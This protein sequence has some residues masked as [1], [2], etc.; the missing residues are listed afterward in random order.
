MLSG[1]KYFG[2]KLPCGTYINKG[3]FSTVMISAN[4]LLSRKDVHMQKWKLYG[5]KHVS[6]SFNRI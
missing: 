3:I 4:M 5:Y 2:V 6:K 1:R